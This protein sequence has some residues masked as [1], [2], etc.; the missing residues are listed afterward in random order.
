[1]KETYEK[2]AADRLDYDLDFDRW[3]DDD[4]YIVAAVATIDDE[5]DVMVDDTTF[6]SRTVKVWLAGGEDGDLQTVHVTITTND[7]RV[8]EECFRIRVRGC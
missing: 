7:G 1:M 6:A 8:K 2:K 5:G 4:D 3:L